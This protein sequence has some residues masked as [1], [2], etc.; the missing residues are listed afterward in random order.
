[1]AAMLSA[2]IFSW[3]LRVCSRCQSPGNAD[4]VS[5]LASGSTAKLVRVISKD[6]L[7]SIVMS[8]PAK[9]YYESHA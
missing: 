5:K 6:T 7:A 4:T 8:S 3:R 9:F 2:K 1:L